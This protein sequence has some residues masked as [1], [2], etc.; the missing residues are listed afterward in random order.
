[1]NLSILLHRP[2]DPGVEPEE[3]YYRDY[4]WGWKYGQDVN[5]YVD[6]E[7]GAENGEEIDDGIRNKLSTK[8]ILAQKI[9]TKVGALQQIDISNRQNN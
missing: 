3:N 2:D 9:C 7:N 1:M 4:T 5:D 8:D 6:G